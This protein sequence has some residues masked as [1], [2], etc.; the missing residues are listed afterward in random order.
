M[1]DAF[2]V[3]LLKENGLFARLILATQTPEC[4]Q[5]W[6]YQY[7]EQFLT[8]SQ[9]TQKFLYLGILQGDQKVSVH[10]MITIQKV[11][12]NVQSVPRSSPDIY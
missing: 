6:L 12:S 2:G 9:L 7:R 3:I 1:S 4:T 10:L 5:M 11:T 8:V